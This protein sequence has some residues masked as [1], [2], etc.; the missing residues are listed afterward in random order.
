MLIQI[1]YWNIA[2]NRDNTKL[3]LQNSHRIDMIVL[4]KP[5]INNKTKTIHN[6]KKYHTIYNNGR[7]VLYIYKRHILTIQ[8][9][10]TGTD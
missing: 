7:V 2:Y 3:I 8:M 10:R 9:L 5:W 1:I 4:Q 6:N